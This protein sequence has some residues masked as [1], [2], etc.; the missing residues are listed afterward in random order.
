MSIT[1]TLEEI[2]Q[3]RSAFADYP[4]AL[5]ALDEIA[6]CEGDL[7]DAAIVLAIQVGQEPD[8][9]DRWL[10]GLVKRWRYVI[11]QPQVKQEFEHGLTPSALSALVSAS[12]LPL[13]LATPVAIY[14]SK[15]NIQDFC[16]AFEAKLQ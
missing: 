4:D 6:D 12:A 8:T 14:V 7:E 5:V 1:V 11:C 9:S 3:W 13:K 2:E 15:T 10:D 16:L